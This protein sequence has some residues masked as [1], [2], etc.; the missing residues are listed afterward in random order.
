MEIFFRPFLCVYMCVCVMCS[1]VLI[2]SE[3]L[4]TQQW[5]N[6]SKRKRDR[7]TKTVDEQV[8]CLIID[9]ILGQF[10]MLRTSHFDVRSLHVTFEYKTVCVIVFKH[11]KQILIDLLTPSTFPLILLFVFNKL[12]NDVRAFWNI[13]FHP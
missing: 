3:L 2:L 7:K 12:S 5:M 11:T 4:C 13:C 8:F 10:W 9:R 1:C 6:E